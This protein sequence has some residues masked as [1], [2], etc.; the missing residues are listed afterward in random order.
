MK[1]AVDFSFARPAAAD[2]VAAGVDAIFY[3]GPARP[4]KGYVDGLRAAGV[5][6]CLVQESDPNR[7]QQGEAA[8]IAD[9][10]YA[11]GRA[12]DLGYPVTCA[13]GYVVSDGSRDNPN[14]G[15]DQIAA[16]AAGVAET[17]K[18]PVFFYGNQYACDAAMHGAPGALGTW[19]P[20]T[21]G[22]GTLLTQEANKPS[23][24]DQTDLNTA[25][26]P[27]G[28]W[29]DQEEDMTPEEHHWLETV[30]G[31]LTGGGEPGPY[32]QMD[33]RIIAGVNTHTDEA[34]K[35]IP[36]GGAHELTVTLTGEAV[37]K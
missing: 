2:L 35:A 37:P 11:D 17:T 13:I 27:Y 3:T 24:I 7:S 31:I 9:A 20:S 19:I 30:Y 29:A 28:N 25:H 12:D 33:A 6:V 8:G 22:T 10:L 36:A 21:W 15:G 5:G 23:P 4:D 14:A 26:A 1:D 34:V 16:Y 32:P 18:R